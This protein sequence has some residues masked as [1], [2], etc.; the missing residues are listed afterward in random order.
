MRRELRA[1]EAA[2]DFPVGDND[3]E[4]TP[5]LEHVLVFAMAA[6]HRRWQLA[7]GACSL[8]ADENRPRR[9]GT[10]H[11]PSG[12]PRKPLGDRLF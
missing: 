5:S 3:D 4:S 7:G 11:G 6:R 1:R 2:C 10:R 8:V 9:L 12:R